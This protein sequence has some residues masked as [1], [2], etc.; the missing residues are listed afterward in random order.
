MERT[1]S[2]E[3]SCTPLS[4]RDRAREMLLMGLRLSEGISAAAFVARTGTALAAA[5]D[6]VILQAAEAEDYLTWHGDCLAATPAG[7]LRLDALL[8][9]LVL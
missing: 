7:R 8:G 6:P 2:G 4:D 5:L 9:A 3:T 1:G